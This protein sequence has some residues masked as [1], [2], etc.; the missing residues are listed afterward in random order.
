M[1]QIVT[2]ALLLP[3]AACA[4]PAPICDFNAAAVLPVTYMS[5]HR[6]VVT[7]TIAGQP[8][9]ML[10][11]SGSGSAI[12]TPSAYDRLNLLATGGFELTASGIS[13]DMTVHKTISEDLTI[14]QTKVDNDPLAIA[15]FGANGPPGHPEVDGL[16]GEDVL[17]RFNVAWDLP[18]NQITLYV[19]PNCTQA[20]TPWAGEYAEEPFSESDEQ[21]PLLP[22]Q[23]DG[24][25][26]SAML[27]SG[28]AATLLQQTDLDQAGIAPQAVSSKTP[29]L[30]GIN[31]RWIAGRYEEFSNA[32]IG[33]ESISDV[34]LMVA[35]THATNKV[36]S[37][38]GE[39][40]LANH[41]VFIDN[42]NHI[43]Y[44]GLTVP[45]N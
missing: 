3:L 15:N 13:G 18:S 26:I 44:I 9:R 40:F 7:I 17:K 6:P 5:G 38:I 30:S 23:I 36:P 19:K 42:A 21:A 24:Q 31:G 16:I 34:W 41:R 10:V 1:H 32:V 11:D 2:L 27:D 14:G 12:L 39:D 28:A 43:A 45:G 22:Y 35:H 37:I 29:R 25:N 20:Q 8:V 33:A 4:A